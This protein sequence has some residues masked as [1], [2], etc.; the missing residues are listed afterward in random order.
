[1][2]VKLEAHGRTAE[3]ETL[4]GELVSC[5][6]QSGLEYIWQ[7][8][9]AYWAGRNP[10]LFPIVGALREGKINVNGTTYEMP[11]HGFARRQEF[12]LLEQGPGWAGLELRENE[13][14]LVQYPFP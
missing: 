10:L 11:Q 4:G 9:P 5:K 1:M 2:R 6:D 12:T 13:A 8:D 3:I 7:G 14:T